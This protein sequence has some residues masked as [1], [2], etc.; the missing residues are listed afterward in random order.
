M[1]LLPG[2]DPAIFRLGVRRSNHLAIPAPVCSKGHSSEPK[3]EK[4]S[5]RHNKAGIS[6]KGGGENWDLVEAKYS[7]RDLSK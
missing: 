4:D 2:L 3:K 7:W 1:Y 5:E 6:A